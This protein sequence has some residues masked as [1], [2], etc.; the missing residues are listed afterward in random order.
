VQVGTASDSDWYSITVPSPASPL[1]LETSTPA[2]GPGQFVNTLNPHL[3]LFDSTGTTLI[4]SGTALGDGRNE[5]IPVT[6]LTAGATYKVRVTAEG[7]TKGEYFLTRNFSPVVTGLTVTSPINEND[8]A[9]VSGTF[10]DPDNRDTH[11]VVITWGGGTPGQP[12]EGST[13]LTLAAGVT[14]FSAS[15]QYL[16]DNPTGTPSDVY[17]IAV[18]VTD[19]H[20]AT[21]GAGTS[22]TVNNVAPVISVCSPT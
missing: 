3:E 17:A 16:D 22:V 8:T 13:T 15:H 2:D 1:R 21:G 12:S 11:T 4:A 18:T 5:F 7:A 10:S 9:T 6:G 14:S 20:G 19:N